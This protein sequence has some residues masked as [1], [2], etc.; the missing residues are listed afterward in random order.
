MAFLIRIVALRCWRHPS[1]PLSMQ[2]RAIVLIQ[3][4]WP[5][6]TLAWFMAVLRLPL[7]FRMTPKRACFDRQWRWLTPQIGATLALVCAAAVGPLHSGT[8]L[9]GLLV[10]F[11]VLQ[12]A[13]QLLLVWKTA[14]TKN[15]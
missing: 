5:V 8:A 9:P 12:T 2:W 13:P 6:Y 10:L 15:A 14:R 1:V 7:G 11:A 4:S 3:S